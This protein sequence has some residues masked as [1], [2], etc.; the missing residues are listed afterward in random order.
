MALRCRERAPSTSSKLDADRGVQVACCLTVEEIPERLADG[1]LY[2]SIP[3][4]TAV[5]KCCCGCGLEVVTPISPTDW[6]FV[7]NG[8]A[9]SLSPSIGNW[10]FPCRSHYW[11]TK[12][13]V[14]WAAPMSDAAIQ[15]GRQFDRRAKDHYYGEQNAS[16][17]YDL[18]F[19][20]ATTPRPGHA[21]R[22]LVA[23]LRTWWFGS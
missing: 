7:F 19:S 5:H 23:R 1:I 18:P 6:E 12:G 10:S 15:A 13:R 14:R 16:E 9:V 22:G 8:A 2:I 21:G 3:F 11:I 4:T 17:P 20:E